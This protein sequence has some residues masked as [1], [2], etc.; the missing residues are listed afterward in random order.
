MTD[1]P[2]DCELP[3]MGGGRILNGCEFVVNAPQDA[4]CY[5][6]FVLGFAFPEERA[7]L[8]PKNTMFICGESPAKKLFTRDFYQQ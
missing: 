3:I 1:L 5:C 6:W 4:H 8:A 7:V 2:S